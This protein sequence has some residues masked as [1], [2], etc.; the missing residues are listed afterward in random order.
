MKLKIDTAMKIYKYIFYL[1]L[2]VATACSSD[3]PIVDIVPSNPKTGEIECN[4]D[5]NYAPVSRTYYED[6]VSIYC[7]KWDKEDRIAICFDGSDMARQFNLLKGEDNP[8]AVFYGPFPD[9]YKEITAVYPFD[10]FKG[11]TSSSVEVS[12]PAIINHTTSKIL[13]GVMPMYAHGTVGALNFYNLMGVLKIPV[14]GEGLLRRVSISS[15][16]G[17]GMSGTGH[18]TIDE[19]NIPNLSLEHNGNALTINIGAVLSMEEPLNLFLPIP[20]TTYANGLK[21]EFEFEGDTKIQE[22]KGPLHFDRSVMRAV[23]PYEIDVPF[24]FDNY[25]IKGNEIWYKSIAQQPTTNELSIISHT[26]SSNNQLGI[27]TT[28][29]PIVK[30][31]GPIFTTPQQITFIKLPNSVQEIGMDGLSGLSIEDFEFPESLKTLRTEAMRQCSELKHIDLNDGLESIGAG[32]FEGC[33]NLKS[34]YIPKSV[35]IIGGYSFLQG[36]E[37]LDHWDGDC[38]LIDDDRHALYSNSS[39]G[40]IS[41]EPS[42]IDI[43]AGC[44]L[45]EYAIPTKA[46]QIQNYALDGCKN[47]KKLIIHENIKSIGVGVLD[48]LETIEC[49]A[50]NPPSFELEIKNIKVIKVPQ[51]SIEQYRRAESWRQYLGKIVPL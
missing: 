6:S 39:Y 20:A 15:M 44:N 7:A 10:I 48:A 28:D 40:M 46:L 50:K 2:L 11:R 26:F 47:L 18:I 22:L 5:N 16:D 34:V 36:T 41:E 21:L 12:L 3:E 38:P 31:G 29:S 27:I 45:T 14:Q 17:Y 9:A 25:E 32:A 13:C 30:I 1:L 33:T 49:Y 4:V 42:M 23:K 51:Q 43:V 24:N 19:N 8:S 37:N 35:Q